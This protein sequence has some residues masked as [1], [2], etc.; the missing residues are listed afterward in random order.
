MATK[1][2][3]RLLLFSA[4]IPA[5]LVLG[6]LLTLAD[7]L[8]RMLRILGAA[9]WNPM[10]SRAR[11]MNEA[12]APA[13]VGVPV[14]DIP[15]SIVILNWNGQALLEES[16]PILENEL[17][18]T[19][20][21]CE[22]IVVDNGSSDDS[23]ALVRAR[24]PDFRVLLLPT[25]VGF[26]E[27]NNAGM[28]A[29]SHNRVLLLNNDMLVQPGFLEPLLDAM[30]PATFAA[31]SQVFLPA[32][33]RREETGKTVARLRHGRLEL[34]HEEISPADE[35]N[36]GIRVLWAGGGSSLYRKDLFLALGGFDSLYSPSYAEDADLSFRAWQAGYSSVLAVRSHVLHKHRSSTRKRFGEQGV[37]RLMQKNIRL[38][39][40]RNFSL[41]TLWKY[42][43]W[44]P[45][46]CAA[47]S[48]LPALLPTLPRWPLVLARRMFGP[49][50]VWGD[51]EILTRAG[52]PDPECGM[53]SAECGVNEQAEDGRR[54]AEGGGDDGSHGDPQS[55]IRT[56]QST[57]PLRILCVSAYV[58]HLWRHG[59]AG[60]VFQLL[61]RVAR[62]HQV[63]VATFYEDDFEKGE[64]EKLREFCRSVTAIHRRGKPA[65]NLFPYEPFAEFDLPEMR[66]ALR[67]LAQ[68]EVFD[69]VHFEFTQ[70]ACYARLFPDAVK[71]LTEVEVNYAAAASKIGYLSNPLAQLK[72]YYNS[73]QVLNRELALCR[74]VDHVICVNETD[75][76]LI[77]GY[78]PPQGV[79]VVPTG[80]DLDYFT[81][82]S[83]RW[84]EPGSIGFVAAFRH[85]P[86]VDAALFFLHDVFPLIKARFPQVRFYLIG[87]SPTEEILQQHNGH[88]ILVTGFV[89]D[90][91]HYY[92]RMAVIVVP[93]RTGVGIRGK[94]L[95]AWAAGKPVVG[96]SVAAAGIEA[97]HGEN[98]YIADLP[99]ELAQWIVRLLESPVARAS[100]AVRARR[101]AEQFYDWNGLA[102][103]LCGLYQAHTPARLLQ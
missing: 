77:R 22:V 91:A 85:E 40:F 78:L 13:G 68:E 20:V 98:M 23:V 30:G 11:E 59:G 101:T 60:R 89:E 25:N 3:K 14:P 24:F 52:T 73:M 5:A 41:A 103:N 34:S 38:F 65:T 93:V 75:A 84:E 49:Y 37:Q 62:R 58:P 87:A 66:A 36:R 88:D 2:L 1:V 54:K 27:G 56:P 51:G 6:T 102:A 31:T 100:L 15:V 53:R 9:R 63:S 95:E 16:L 8:G 72:W 47:H 69:I 46:N 64:C 99:E 4:A 48:E 97:S 90:L 55:A 76:E 81:A 83:H 94:V 86:N 33:V 26:G 71:F 12:P 67:R 43:L 80:V 61:R 44:L 79:H 7:L 39:Y 74:S 32:A 21:P 92:R 35:S 29:A 45:A 50:P 82:D 96:T 57:R 42:C 18:R 19:S 17:R 70:M 10:P 28:R